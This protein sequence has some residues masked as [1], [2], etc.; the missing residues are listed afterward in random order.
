MSY[1]GFRT[2]STDQLRIQQRDTGKQQRDTGKQQRDTGGGVAMSQSTGHTAEITPLK[3]NR[4]ALCLFIIVAGVLAAIAP[5]IRDAAEIK[6]Y[7][8]AADRIVAGQQFYR[9]DDPPA[10]SYP[11]FSVLPFTLLVPF[12]VY[13]REVLWWFTNLLLLGYCIYVVTALCWP[14]IQQGIRSGG[15]PVIVN[16]ILISLLSA[17]HL[18]A[19]IGY[20][21]NDLI[22]F[23]CLLTSAWWLS[24]Q[25]HALAGISAGVAA[26][27]KATPLLFIALLGMQRR[28][29]ACIAML[30]AIGIAS[31]LPDLI[32]GSPNGQLLARTW[33]QKFVAKLDVGSAPQVQG[34]WQAWNPI[35]QSVSGT[36]HRYFSDH[37]ARNPKHARSAL[38]IPLDPQQ[39]SLIT[40]LSQIFVLLLVCRAVFRKESASADNT[41][42]S[43][44]ALGQVSAVIC[45]M[46]LL[47]PM[48]STQHFCM[49][50]APFSFLATHWV[51]RSRDPVTAAAFVFL[52]VVSLSGGKDLIGSS[53][54]N[55]AQDFGFTMWGTLI[56]LVATSDILSRGY[57]TATVKNASGVVSNSA[58]IPCV[59]PTNEYSAM[60]STAIPAA[61]PAL[62]SPAK[63]AA[64]A[65]ACR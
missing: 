60:G 16:V 30:I 20:Q 27:C 32:Y 49:L 21:S 10:Y 53:L 55:A 61:E 31:I 46:L 40:R 33:Y 22:V 59:D 23:A 38:F 3:I 47:S 19:V 34:T 5:G 7:M 36:T 43:W 2:T 8:K 14:T 50:L 12:D 29:V 13:L 56:A 18:L 51:Y 24:R 58:I 57:H 28:F 54:K 35:N 6:V 26:A 44:I 62:H 48:S 41:E 11:P 64:E 4:G 1:S 52:L 25:R 37:N 15:P 17:R 45:G 65:V 42:C 9:T 63:E 39:I